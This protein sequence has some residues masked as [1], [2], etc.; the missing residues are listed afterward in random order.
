MAEKIIEKVGLSEKFGNL[1]FLEVESK[2]FYLLEGPI[3]EIFV[4]VILGLFN[5]IL[6]CEKIL[7]RILRKLIWH[8]TEFGY[9]D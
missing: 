6:L 5:S 7:F 9:I 8:R 4:L 2:R 3:I 1:K